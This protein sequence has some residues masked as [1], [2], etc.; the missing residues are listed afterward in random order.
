MVNG[1]GNI[2]SA[3]HADV[4]HCSAEPAVLHLLEGGGSSETTVGGQLALWAQEF[5]DL[6]SRVVKVD[7]NVAW[8]VCARNG[9]GACQEPWDYFHSVA[10]TKHINRSRRVMS[11]D[12]GSFN[13]C[14]GVLTRNLFVLLL[15]RNVWVV[16]D[17]EQ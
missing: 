16:R 9:N 14:V 7:P 15:L 3:N 5:R 12:G 17:R 4:L 11:L 1:A 8:H 2:F 6:R 13:L 10:V